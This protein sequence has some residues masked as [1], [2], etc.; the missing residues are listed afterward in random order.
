MSYKVWFLTVASLAF[1]SIGNGVLAETCGPIIAGSSG[2]EQ[3]LIDCMS[4]LHEKIDALTTQNND[5]KQEIQNT[6]FQSLKIPSGAVMAFDLS[7]SS[8]VNC[9]SGWSSHR[10]LRGRTIVGAGI[11]TNRDKFGVK[12]S[13]LDVGANGGAEEHKLTQD[14]MPQHMHP[15]TVALQDRYIA[16]VRTATNISSVNTGRVDLSTGAWSK[17][18]KTGNGAGS[19]DYHIAFSTA[20]Q[21]RDLTLGAVSTGGNVAHNN[22]QPYLALL[23]CIKE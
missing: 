14:E 6:D 17:Y 13:S 21:R 11:H 8:P 1:S 16:G 5:L 12:I 10:E 18:F 3:K 15:E 4:S 19:T 23:Y 22:M 20:S 9:P 7:P 2:S